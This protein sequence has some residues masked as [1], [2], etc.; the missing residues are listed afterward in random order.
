MVKVDPEALLARVCG[1]APPE[2]LWEL[3]GRIAQ[4]TAVHLARHLADPTTAPAPDETIWIDLADPD[5][6]PATGSPDTD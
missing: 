4:A 2:R 3:V 5:R 6:S 1:S